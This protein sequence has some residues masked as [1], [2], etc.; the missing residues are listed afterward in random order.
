MRRASSSMRVDR[1]EQ[2]RARFLDRGMVGI[3][4][5]GDLFETAVQV[6]EQPAGTASLLFGPLSMRW[7]TSSRR[8]AQVLECVAGRVPRR[9]SRAARRA[10]RRFPPDAFRPCRS[11][12]QWPFPRPGGQRGQTRLDALEGR[13]IEFHGWAETDTVAIAL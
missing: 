12:T 1:L 5:L 2:A 10:V 11:A 9:S 6:V 13:G 4:T 8:R 7:T 3:E